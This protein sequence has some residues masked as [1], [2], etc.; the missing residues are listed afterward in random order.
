MR[1]TIADLGYA[2]HTPAEVYGSAALAARVA[3]EVWLADVGRRGWAVLGR[4]T[5]IFE[6]PLETEAYRRARIHMFLFPGEATRAE[7]VDLLNA[8]LAAICTACTLRA[9]AAYL[10]RRG[11]LRLL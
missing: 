6:R 7:L 3:D 8:N 4:D 2:V 5:K 1:R 11:A 9:P 10:V